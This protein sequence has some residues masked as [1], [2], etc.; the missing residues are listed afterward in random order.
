MNNKL[1]AFGDQDVQR[2]QVNSYDSGHEHSIE[3]LIELRMMLEASDEE[4]DV[5]DRCT[6]AVCA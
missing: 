6:M 4:K 1:E 2:P 3:H 5:S